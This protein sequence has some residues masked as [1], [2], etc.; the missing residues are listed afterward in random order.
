MR[1]SPAERR[2]GLTLVELLITV[3]IAGIA[4]AALVPLFVQA[5]K[6]N[7]ADKMRSVA[8]NIAQSKI[9]MLREVDF[10]QIDTVTP[11][12]TSPTD[13]PDVAGFIPKYLGNETFHQGDFKLY[14][15]KETA[16]GSRRFIV[17]YDVTA[18]KNAPSDREP[19]YKVVRVT[20]GWTGNPKPVKEAVLQTVI[21]RQW[22]GP[23]IAKFEVTPFDPDTDIITGSPVR[24]E[25]VIDSLDIA[26]TSKVEFAIT[27]KN[28]DVIPWQPGTQESDGKIWSF[29]WETTGVG[30]ALYSF[31]AIAYAGL[32]AGSI[33]Q[34]DLRIET[35]PP[36]EPRDV[37]W[38]PGDGKVTLKWAPNTEGDFAHYEVYRADAQIAPE[39]VEDQ[40]ERVDG[41]D[42]LRQPLFADEGLT[43]GQPYYYYLRAVDELGNK[44]DWTEVVATPEDVDLDPPVAPTQL[45]FSAPLD[46]VTLTWA[47]STSPDLS[48]YQV[49]KW[50]TVTQMAEL[51]GTPE[52]ASFTYAQGFSTTILYQV[53]A[54][55]E[56][57]NPSTT[58]A[59]IAAGT[60]FVYVA[61]TGTDWLQ[62]ATGPPPLFDLT[63]RNATGVRQAVVVY[64]LPDWPDATTR[65]EVGSRNNLNNMAE[66]TV[67]DQPMAWYQ[68]TWSNGALS[69]NFQLVSNTPISIP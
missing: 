40:A 18:V 60:P 54:V 2:K 4:F 68:V 46:V 62:A 41:E 51:I 38:T 36:G 21:Y 43:N 32:E 7:S 65:V 13:D 33:W 44:G 61:A 53:K 14:Y 63:V 31:K 1:R 23:R 50:D 25:A 42:G 12:I 64:H 22:G 59:S 6:S 27:S 57:G 45:T 20:V 17:E 66:L 35:G 69:K 29:S 9:E 10:Y 16:A 24:L 28:G 8:V 56:A 37:V 55:D 30:D 67:K 49:F 47:P 34:R 15:D 26:R 5:Q 11:D 39:Q 52:T 48:Y 19:A 3:V 58:F